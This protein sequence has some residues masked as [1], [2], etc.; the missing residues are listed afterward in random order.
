[1][2]PSSSC[3]PPPLPPHPHHHS[4]APAFWSSLPRVRQ[5]TEI[6]DWSAASPHSA[7]Y[8]LWDNG[9]KNLYRVGFEGMVSNPQADAH[10]ERGRRGCSGPP[11]C[12]STAEEKK[13]KGLSAPQW[14][15]PFV[16][17][18][19]PACAGSIV[20][21]AGGGYLHDKKKSVP[22]PPFFKEAIGRTWRSLAREGSTCLPPPPCFSLHCWI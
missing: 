21:A 18:M 14:L 9:A 13:S 17:A 5:V 1:M 7:A 2:D 19:Q 6:Q 16:K 22:S 15:G 20:W 3:A 4:F 12:L 11:L 10:K 8:V